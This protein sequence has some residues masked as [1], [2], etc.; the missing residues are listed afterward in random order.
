MTTPK[1]DLATTLIL[2]E[3]FPKDSRIEAWLVESAGP[4]GNTHQTVELVP[5]RTE[6]VGVTEDKGAALALK[7]VPVH[8]PEGSILVMTVPA[9][10]STAEYHINRRLL[11]AMVNTSR[12]IAGVQL[13][14]GTKLSAQT[15]EEL[16]HATNA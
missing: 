6:P 1:R 2:Q 11:A 15:M 5:V 16:Q 10:Q 3:D 12:A 4:W 8:V 13:P 7:S 14:E 9:N